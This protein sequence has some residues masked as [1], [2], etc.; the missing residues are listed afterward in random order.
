MMRRRVSRRR[1]RNW[2]SWEMNSASQNS[3]RKRRRWSLRGKSLLW[4]DERARSR[5]EGIRYRE[6][7]FWRRGPPYWKS[8]IRFSQSCT[9]RGFDSCAAGGSF[10]VVKDIFKNAPDI[11]GPL[12]ENNPEGEDLDDEAEDDNAE[13]GVKF[14]PKDLQGFGVKFCRDWGKEGD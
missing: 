9:E 1:S 6:L 7:H 3:S 13:I 4:M 14:P 5:R 11:L 8:S 2:V 10:S 12:D